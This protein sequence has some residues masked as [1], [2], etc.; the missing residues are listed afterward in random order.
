VKNCS[1][2]QYLAIEYLTG[3]L[4]IPPPGLPRLKR[5]SLPNVIGRVDSLGHLLPSLEQFT[6]LEVIDEV[7][8]ESSRSIHQLQGVHTLPP[9]NAAALFFD[10]RQIQRYHRYGWNVQ[11][12]DKL[13]DLLRYTHCTIDYTW[14]DG[15]GYGLRTKK[16]PLTE[17]DETKLRQL[18]GPDESTATIQLR[19]QMGVGG[20]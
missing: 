5:F 9:A 4:V 3:P 20:V 6:V 19:E 17:Q 10:L 7:R 14:C 1:S 13:C 18:L 11:A 2:L 8:Y 12:L 16:G 15:Y